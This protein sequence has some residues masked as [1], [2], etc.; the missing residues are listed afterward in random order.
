MLSK[1]QIN[2][3][4]SSRRLNKY[5]GWRNW[6]TRTLEVRVALPYEFESRHPHNLL[7][8]VG[9][10]LSGVFAIA[11]RLEKLWKR[12]KLNFMSGANWL[13]S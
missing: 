11:L 2:A 7:T 9:P 8:P 12:Y 6:Y 10:W 1:V 4:K 3:A 13:I 5:R